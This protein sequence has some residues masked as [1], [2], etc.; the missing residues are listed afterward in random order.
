MMQILSEL[1][2][3]QDVSVTDAGPEDDAAAKQQAGTAD[4]EHNTSE[5]SSPQQP[6]SDKVH[7]PQSCQ[8]I[9]MLQRECYEMDLIG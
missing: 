8:T 9:Q 2:I 7:L 1:A 3:L 4:T 5:M 6:S